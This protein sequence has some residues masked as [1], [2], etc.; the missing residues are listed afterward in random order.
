MSMRIRYVGQDGRTR[1]A[2]INRIK[3]VSD[4]FKPTDKR[5]EWDE[6]FSGPAIIVHTIRAKG[7]KRL[8]FSI[9]DDFP[10][11]GAKAHMLEEGWLDLSPCPLKM[12]NLY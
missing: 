10:I 2:E 8:T 3:F 4:G 5:G 11:E 12:E 9:P 1:L 7:G 6:T